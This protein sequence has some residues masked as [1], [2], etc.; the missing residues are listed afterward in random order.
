MEAASVASSADGGASLEVSVGLLKLVLAIALEVLYTLA[1]VKV[2]SNLLIS[3]YKH[4]KFFVK[5][6]ILLLQNSDVT[7][8]SGNLSAETSVSIGNSGIREF[9]VVIFLANNGNLVLT[10]SDLRLQVED[11][12]LK[13]L[14][15]LNLALLLS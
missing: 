5:I 10:S 15:A 4:F 3:L 8:K 11:N 2:H 13:V 7:L 1:T 6:S 9:N 14:A 12:S